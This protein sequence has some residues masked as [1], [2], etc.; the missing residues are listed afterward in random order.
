MSAVES[1]A[2]S[3]I[4]R[5]CPHVPSCSSSFVCHRAVQISCAI[6]QLEF[7]IDSGF[8]RPRAAQ[9]PVPSFSS[10]F[11]V[12]SCGSI[13]HDPGYGPLCPRAAQGPVMP[14]PVPS[15]APDLS[16]SPDPADGGSVKDSRH[17]RR[18]RTPDPSPLPDPADRGSFKRQRQP[19]I[20]V[21]EHLPKPKKPKEDRSMP[22][23]LRGLCNKDPQGRRICFGFNLGTC[24]DTDNCS[25]GMHKCCK[26]MCFG[27]HPQGQCSE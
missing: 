15:R 11:R 18:S 6:A 22:E 5:H 12:P 2:V 7:V 23:G 19:K 17:A 1:D 8:V 14:R 26:P 3:M 4:L 25:K 13:Q 10:S 16:P 24:P 21:Q 20:H 9:V 27:K